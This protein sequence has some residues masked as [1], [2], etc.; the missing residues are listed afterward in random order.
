M[1]QFIDTVVAFKLVWF[2][3]LMY[4]LIPSLSTFISLTETWSG[5]TWEHT[6]VFLRWR[7]F[8]SCV[9]PGFA[10]IVG[11]IDASFQKVKEEMKEKQSRNTP[12]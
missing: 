10:A 3:V 8:V 1:K 5:E 6:H 9:L 11:Y 12:V 4:L 7:L 2:R